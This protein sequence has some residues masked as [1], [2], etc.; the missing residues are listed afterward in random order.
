MEV[1]RVGGRII[2]KLIRFSVLLFEDPEISG[3]NAP[4]ISTKTGISRGQNSFDEK[5]EPT[6]PKPSVINHSWHALTWNVTHYHSVKLD[7]TASRCQLIYKLIGEGKYPEPI[8]IN[9]HPCVSMQSNV[10]ELHQCISFQC[11]FKLELV[12]HECCAEVK[13]EGSQ[14]WTLYSKVVLG[15]LLR[16]TI[17]RGL[18]QYSP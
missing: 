6:A 13:V 16:S 1:F 10:S 4:L 11:V 18:V 9:A 3:I 2:L 8:Y 5:E 12:T 14:A 7:L 15:G 17:P